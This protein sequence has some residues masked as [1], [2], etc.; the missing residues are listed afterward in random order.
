[1]SLTLIA[2]LLCAA[3]WVVLTFVRPAGLG[4][5][6]LLLAAAA[7]VWV[8]WWATRDAPDPSA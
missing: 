8:R 1:M 7:I 6:H 2:S 5:A 3:L 4:V